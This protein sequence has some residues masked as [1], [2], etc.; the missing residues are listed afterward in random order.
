ML[1]LS[2]GLRDNQLHQQENIL[3]VDDAIRCAGSIQV[4]MSKLNG[5]G[6]AQTQRKLCCDHQVRCIDV[7]IRCIPGCKVTITITI[8]I[9]DI[10]G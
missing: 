10:G 8:T 9:T 7:A 2:G 4:T 6:C 1:C 3:Q 5:S